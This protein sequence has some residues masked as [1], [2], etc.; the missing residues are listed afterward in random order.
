[1]LLPPKE[2]KEALTVFMEV[3]DFLVHTYICD[4]NFGYMAN[5]DS[6]DP[7]HEFFLEETRQP[8]LVYRRDCLDE[9]LEFFKKARADGL[10]EPIV[11]TSA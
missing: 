9:T 3:D 11:Y 2:K 7:E 6:K 1:V 4:E 5:P 8:V 10:I